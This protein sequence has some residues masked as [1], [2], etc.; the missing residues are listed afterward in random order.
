MKK[1][2]I[3]IAAFLCGPVFA[4]LVAKKTRLWIAV[5]ALVVGILWISEL[6][7]SAYPR[8]RNIKRS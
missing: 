1:T 4:N 8:S 7:A 5:A 6:P 3:S 2:K